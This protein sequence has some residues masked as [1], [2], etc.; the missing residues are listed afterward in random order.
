LL[1]V[2]GTYTVLVDPDSTFTGS[3]TM[4]L[5]TVPPDVTGTIEIN[6]SPLGVTI[7]A[8]AQN[9]AI[10]FSGTAGQSVTV[11]VRNNTMTDTSVSYVNVNLL[12]PDGTAL[13]T[14]Y[15]GTSNDVTRT[16]VTTGTYTIKVDPI[17]STTG[18]LTL[19][20]TTP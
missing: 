14:S 4:A 17:G 11:R 12:K 15:P 20:V 19:S 13:F 7:G 3:A 16:L 2:T 18:S 9:A 5:S 8:P 1:P 6:G 10:T